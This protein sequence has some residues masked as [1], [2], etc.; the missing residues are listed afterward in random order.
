M[1]TDDGALRGRRILVAASGSIAAVKTPLLVS[2]LVQAGAEVRCLLTPSAEHLVSPVAM[3]TLSRHRCYRDQDQ[4]DPG[5]S[6]PLHIELAEWAEL[7]VVAPLSATTLGRWSQ[8]LAD[9]LLASTLLACERPV[10]AAAA[11]NTAMWK[12]PAVQANW[13]SIQRLPGVIPL[14]PTAGLLACDR[15]GDG[16]MADPIQIELAAAVLFSRHEGELSIDRSWLGRRLLVSAGSTLES[17]DQARLISNRSSGRMGVLLA[18]VARLRGADVELVHG[19][20]QVPQA[21]LE[22][23]DCESV[24]SAD[25]MQQALH[26]RQDQASALAMVAAVADLRR[27]GGGLPSKPPKSDLPQLL[28]QG[29][30][31]VPDLLEG[32]VNRRPSGQRILGFAALTG[33]D[34]EL[35]LRG[36]EK[37]LRKGCDLLMVNPID[38][39]GEGFG[40]D[41]AS[42]WLLG[43]GLQQRVPLTSKLALAHDLLDALAEGLATPSSC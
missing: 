15:H 30:E 19:P 22:G 8:G 4:W 20:L 16:R 31:P 26:R 43:D 5:R 33:S 39:V 11:M 18:Q 13:Q 7:M 37:R 6:R 10:L 36:G 40:E 9:G 32:L 14:S 34:E 17:I 35:L 21:W 3:A 12:H 1:R 25:Q 29:W 23:L 27:S 2:G 28:E 41:N 38:R 24:E 42:G